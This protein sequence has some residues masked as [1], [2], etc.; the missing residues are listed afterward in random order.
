MTNGMREIE[1]LRQ[2]CEHESRL[3]AAHERI[4]SCVL[5]ALT[6]EQFQE[7]KQAYSELFKNRSTSHDAETEVIDKLA[8][9]MLDLAESDR[10]ARAR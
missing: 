4:L 10:R 5:L 3:R 7:L 1:A 9:S 8:A 6:D 2:S